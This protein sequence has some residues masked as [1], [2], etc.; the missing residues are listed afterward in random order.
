VA[1]CF[2]TTAGLRTA[3]K[4]AGMEVTQQS[5]EFADALGELANMVAGQAKSK[6]EGLNINVSLPRVIVGNELRLLDSSQNPVLVLPCDSPLG[7]FNT[8]VV[9]TLQRAPSNVTH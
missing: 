2:S 9:M 6:L 8:E 5:P 7:R 4:F 3:G 1:L